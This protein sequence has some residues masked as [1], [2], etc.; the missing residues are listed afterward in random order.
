MRKGSDFISRKPLGP[1]PCVIWDFNGTLIDDKWIA[2]E[3]NIEMNR[4]RGKQELTSEYYLEQFTHPPKDFY[5]KMGYTFEDEPYEQ[6]SREFLS[7]YAKRQGKAALS[8]GVIPALEAFQEAGMKQLIISAHKEELL[9]E[10]VRGLGIEPFFSHIIG[11]KDD[12]VTGK[13]ER[14]LDFASQAG[15]DLSQAVFVGD[16]DHDLETARALGCDCVLYSG[17]HQAKARL[18]Q[19]GVPVFETMQEAARWILG[20]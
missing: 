1:Y 13:V 20:Q 4:K 5:M 18:E 10:Q 8:D 11:T 3:I 2:I 17:G 15:F 12:V 6:V 19:S 14:A 7:E 9:R 16:T